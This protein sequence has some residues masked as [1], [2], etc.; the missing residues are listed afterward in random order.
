MKGKAIF[1]FALV[2]TLFSC[3][4]RIEMTP[5]VL[6]DLIRSDTIDDLSVVAVLEVFE[7]A[8]CKGNEISANVYKVR[9]MKYGDTLYVFDRCKKLKWTK[10]DDKISRE[11]YLFMIVKDSLQGVDEIWL[12]KSAHV[13]PESKFLFGRVTQPVY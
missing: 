9:T 3:S 5:V 2:M 8:P 7:S 4:E 10:N 1:S 11:G 12:A 6:S 13:S